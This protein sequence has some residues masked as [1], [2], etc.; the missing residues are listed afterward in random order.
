MYKQRTWGISISIIYI[1][2]YIIYK[3]RSSA[4][5]TTTYKYLDWIKQKRTEPSRKISI[6]S[7]LSHNTAQHARAAC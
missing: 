3:D 2:I 7:A 6:N 1:Y 5:L 4:L